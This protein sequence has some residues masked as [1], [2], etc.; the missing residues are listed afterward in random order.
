M[1]QC[2]YRPECGIALQNGGKYRSNLGEVEAILGAVVIL[3]VRFC[4]IRL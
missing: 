1:P 2:F 3:G 4:F